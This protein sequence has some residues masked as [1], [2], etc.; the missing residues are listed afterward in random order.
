MSW[1]MSWNDTAKAAALAAQ[2]ERTSAT[3]RISVY[4]P[5]SWNPH[6]I[7][8]SRV[9]Q[10]RELASPTAPSS[11]TTQPLQGKARRD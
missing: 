8:L 6:D 4:T 2:A 1:P 7:W 5:W 11:S 3:G 9:K 10:S